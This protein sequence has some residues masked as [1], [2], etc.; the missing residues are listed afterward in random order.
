MKAGYVS[1]PYF[2]GKRDAA[3][4]EVQKINLGKLRKSKTG[5]V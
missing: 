1:E 5:I 3:L 2:T 4:P